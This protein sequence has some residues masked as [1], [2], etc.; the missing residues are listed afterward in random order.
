L[1]ESATSVEANYRAACNRRSRAEFISKLCIVAEE[2]DETVFWL[3]VVI[4]AGF[5]PVS[6]LVAHEQEAIE[7][8]AIFSRSVG[9]ARLN[10]R[11]QQQ[12]RK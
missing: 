9:T 3:E 11:L 4:Q 2:A 6:E 5:L 1:A 12:G 7:R 10:S 8:R